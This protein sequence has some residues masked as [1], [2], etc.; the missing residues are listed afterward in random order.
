GVSCPEGSR[1]LVAA[2][3]DGTVRRWAWRDPPEELPG[4][5]AGTPAPKVAFTPDGKTMARGGSSGELELWTF[6]DPT[7]AAQRV[8]LLQPPSVTPSRMA[9]TR[10]GGTL[11]TLGTRGPFSVG[12]WDASAGRLRDVVPGANDFALSP[13]GKTLAAWV[14]GV[15]IKLW[16]VGSM[17]E[18]PPL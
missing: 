2:A 9:L 8:A 17:K 14:P 13:D 15:G 4:V 10:D 7:G 16:D 11:V 12:V 5:P 18:R 6:P 1:T 3:S